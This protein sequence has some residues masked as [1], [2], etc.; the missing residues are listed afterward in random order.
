MQKFRTLIC[1]LTVFTFFNLKAQTTQNNCACCTEN[2]NQF[3]FWLGEW[4]VYDGNEE[5][6]GVNSITKQD[7]NCLIQEK[8]VNDQRK[9]TSTLYYN[10]ADNFWNQIWADNNGFVLKLK[11]NMVEGI[12]I[13]KSELIIGNNK[14]YYNKISWTVNNDETITQL[15]EIYNEKDIKISELFKGIY[16]KT[17]N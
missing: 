8:W 3:D 13:L 14:K 10:N 6:I 2:Y 7:G 15:W 16:K 9:G 12:M 17:L 1:L 11:G 5:F 4:N